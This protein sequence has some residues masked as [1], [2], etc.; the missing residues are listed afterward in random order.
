MHLTGI[1]QLVKVTLRNPL[2][3]KDQISYTIKVYDS[4]LSQDWISA[5]KELL[6]NKNFN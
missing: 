4:K 3:F 1:N 2:D 6:T 5:L